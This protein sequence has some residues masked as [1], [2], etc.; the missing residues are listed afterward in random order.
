[1]GTGD[2]TRGA[3]YCQEDNSS[4]HSATELRMDILSAITMYGWYKEAP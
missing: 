4:Q 3:L 1:M 2:K